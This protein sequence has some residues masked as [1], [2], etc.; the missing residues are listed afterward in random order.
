MVV[1]FSNGISQPSCT[2]VETGVVCLLVTSGTGPVRP[3]KMTF[4]PHSLTPQQGTG[5]SLVAQ[6]AKNLPAMQETRVRSM[7]QEDSP[8]EENDNLLQYSC[9][10]N[11]LDKRTWQATVHGVTKSWT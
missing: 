2:Q 1:P 8:G 10:E 7:G 11:F 9:L 3:K 5:S 4:P 6:T